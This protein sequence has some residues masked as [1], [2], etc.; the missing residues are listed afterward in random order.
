MSS[1][2]TETGS[3]A[4]EKRGVMRASRRK[5]DSRPH[6]CGKKHREEHAQVRNCPL[7]T[8]EA[9]ILTLKTVVSDRN[10]LISKFLIITS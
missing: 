9:P 4:E 2:D 5:H 10:G 3:K 7:T 1:D 8:M 6:R